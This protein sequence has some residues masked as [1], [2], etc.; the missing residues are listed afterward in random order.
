MTT[1]KCIGEYS[2]TGSEMTDLCRAIS[3]LKRSG[4]SPVESDFYRTHVDCPNQL[5]SGLRRF[6]GDFR[7]DDSLSACLVHNFTVDYATAG[8]T[9]AHWERPEGYGSTAESDTYLAM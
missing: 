5:P 6:L 4:L 2:L 8:P 9:P 1:Q 7:Y 3:E